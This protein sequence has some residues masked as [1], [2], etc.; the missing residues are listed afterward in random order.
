MKSMKY[1]KF[2][3]VIGALLLFWIPKPSYAFLDTV[4]VVTTFTP[5]VIT[6][7][8]TN[9]SYTARILATDEAAV[10]TACG[11][12]DIFVY[13]TPAATGQNFP[14]SYFLT[15]VTKTVQGNFIENPQ[16]QYSIT[17]TTQVKCG[18]GYTTVLAQTTNTLQTQGQP[19]GG[20]DVGVTFDATPTSMNGSS[21]T[22]NFKLSYTGKQA[23]LDHT[24]GAGKNMIWTIYQTA[25]PNQLGDAIEVKRGAIPQTNFGAGTTINVSPDPSATVNNPGHLFYFQA[26]ATCDGSTTPLNTSGPAPTTGVAVSGVDG[27]GGGTCGGTGQPAC[28][29]IPAGQ[30]QVY[31]F[32]ITNPL[33]GGPNNIF[34]IITIITQWIMYISIPLAVLW[35][36]YAGFLMLT[37]GPNPA[38]FTKGRDILKFVVIG[39]A[40]IFIGKGFVSLIISV[41]E[42]GGTGTTPT[43]QTQSNA[44]GTGNG[45]APPAGAALPETHYDC[46]ANDQCVVDSTNNYTYSD[47]TSCQ[48]ACGGGATTGGKRIGQAC[49]AGA[50]PPDCDSD[51]VCGANSVCQRPGGNTAGETCYTDANCQTGTTCQ[52]N[53]LGSDMLCTAN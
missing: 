50:Q 23:D 33:A 41:I 14:E 24:C 28:P 47:F 6:Y 39:L 16:S 45:T 37:A 51:L 52:D 31:N 26:R 49:T 1:Y 15:S 44:S 18:T 4:K 3:G 48:D 21:S 11:G 5:S 42:L 53:P 34:D 17:Y 12:S 36:M 10:H 46:G 29:P 7:P 32:S 38:N 25:V 27:S 13:I 8:T 2:L 22:F 9:M 43:T 35:I 20:G 19:S 40:I 30:N